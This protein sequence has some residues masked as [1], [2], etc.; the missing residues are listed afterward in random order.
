MLTAHDLNK[1]YGL[2]TVLE[3]ISFSLG[4]G[5]RVGLIGPNGCGKTTLLRILIGAEPADRGRV[6]LN[7]PD[8]RIGYLSQGLDLPQR[9]T[10]SE[11]LGLP[12]A[13]PA[14]HLEHLSAALAAH[15]QDE[16]LR[17]EYDTVL[18]RLARQP[19]L[20]GLE[21]VLV[22]LGLG[23]VSPDQA[24]GLLSGGQKTRLALA[25][26]L[27]A[28]PNLLLLDEPTNHLDIQMLEWLEGWLADF[29]GAAL[30]VSHD[31]T[32]LDRAVTRILELDASTH[33]L[34]AY[35]ANY[36]GYLELRLAEQERQL[37]DYADWKEQISRLRRAAAHVRSLTV[38]K[39]GG[40]AD[41]GDKFAKGFFAGRATKRVAK[42]A[43]VIEER[44]DKLTRVGRVEK[45]RAAWQMKLDLG[46]AG[47]LGHDALALEGLTLGYPHQPIL[48]DGVSAYLKGG[49]RV[50]L[51]GPNGCGKTTLL[52]AIA[53]EL[54]PIGGSLRV[55]VNVHL[56]VMSQEQEQIDPGASALALV[57]AVAPVN[58]T[59]ARA[60][61]HYFLFTGDDA[62]RP[63]REL[64]YGE[65]ARLQLALL[66]A[67]GCNFL[68]LDEPI[69][70]LDIPSRTRFEEALAQFEGTVLAVVHDRYFIERFASEIWLIEERKI[71]TIYS[72]PA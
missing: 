12:D 24:V 54:P 51:T 65:R 15:P 71:R 27:L 16:S 25:R 7:R 60:F 56:G 59:E 38:M 68:L 42:R 39:K 2:Q 36:S 9:L 11:A 50:V 29:P 45:P 21:E 5:D 1:S 18:Q 61:L 40:K 31:R 37:Q 62:L 13:D 64:S 66:V 49:G 55:G 32:F 58:Q 19:P 52:R 41:R 26:I 44:L 46:S 69:N 23:D 4:P 53:G 17:G 43:R 57:Q 34:R 72:Q 63:A 35:E 30:I 33:G 6:T 3:N 70:H 28:S 14:T 22:A 48:L 8:V 47:H 20:A 10:L 67:R